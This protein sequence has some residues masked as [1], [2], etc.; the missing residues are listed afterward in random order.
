[1]PRKHYANSNVPMIKTKDLEGHLVI[2][3]KSVT[4]T[5]LEEGTMCYNSIN[6]V[7]TWNSGDIT[8]LNFGDPDLMIMYDAETELLTFTHGEK[9]L[10]FSLNDMIELIKKNGL[11]E[12]EL[13]ELLE[14]TEK[15]TNDGREET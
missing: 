5:F 13:T 3:S 4:S 6:N 8:H 11:T 12:E 14:K 9:N 1:M 10:Y 2:E 7:I 15:E